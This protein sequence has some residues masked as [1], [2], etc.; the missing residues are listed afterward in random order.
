MQSADLFNEAIGGANIALRLNTRGIRD[1]AWLLATGFAGFVLLA[2]DFPPC[3]V[4]AVFWFC[5]AFAC[6]AEERAL[7]L[8]VPLYGM[9]CR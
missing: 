5:P 6:L 2:G 4:V 3:L 7:I 8:T 1:L 9:R